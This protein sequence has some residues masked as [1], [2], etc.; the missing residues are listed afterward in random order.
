[1]HQS[2]CS[3]DTEREAI[4]KKNDEIDDIVVTNNKMPN[5]AAIDHHEYRESRLMTSVALLGVLL[6][7]I[8]VIIPRVVDIQALLSNKAASDDGQDVGVVQVTSS[9]DYMLQDDGYR[10][11]FLHIPKNGGSALE[12]AARKGG[13]TWGICHFPSS[14]HA[15]DCRGLPQFEGKEASMTI[16]EE[17]LPPGGNTCFWHVPLQRLGEFNKTIENYDTGAE[18][19]QH[20]KKR[21]FAVL[22]N[23][24]DRLLSY[25]YFVHREKMIE[26]VAS[27]NRVVNQL[28]DEWNNVSC[29]LEFAC[30]HSMCFI[31]QYDY[32]YD[33]KG[34]RIVHHLIHFENFKEDFD[35]LI[36]QY[37]MNITLVYSKTG[38]HHRPAHSKLNASHFGRQAIERINWFY[39]K[40]FALGGYD[41]IDPQQ[42]PER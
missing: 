42:V 14:W 6:S 29:E 1:M 5:S 35:H 15:V 10:L 9:S 4:H 36:Q 33:G 26:G 41:I 32:V 24:Y 37:S 19:E 39:R 22:R 23:P 8:F 17:N 18:P 11:E 34:N 25:L 7:I 13:Y 12:Y 40:D 3:D 16:P 27:M 21:F 2:P 31:P 20:K 28:L 38:I 30:P